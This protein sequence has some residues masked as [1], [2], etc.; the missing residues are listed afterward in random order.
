MFNLLLGE[1]CNFSRLLSP[2]DFKDDC[3]SSHN[4]S[5]F[6]DYTPII[7]LLERGKIA[8][9][10][11][12]ESDTSGNTLY[13]IGCLLYLKAMATMFS[14]GQGCG[15][16]STSMLIDPEVKEVIDEA[17]KTF[18]RGIEL[19][20]EH[21]GCWNGLGLCWLDDPYERQVCFTQAVKLGENHAGLTN[22]G[23]TS[24]FHGYIEDANVHR[25]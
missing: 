24:L 25:F 23:V 3:F 6:C 12:L 20:P 11:L 15:I 18:I 13:S 10:S 4:T 5:T 21:G 22:M 7:E 1:F 9:E 19:Q 14:R 16:T 2:L 17:K 8:Y